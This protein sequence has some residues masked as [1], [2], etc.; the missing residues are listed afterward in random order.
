MASIGQAQETV[1]PLLEK[2]AA[3]Y[4]EGCPGCTIDRRKAEFTG[5]PFAHIINISLLILYGR[6]IISLPIATLHQQ[7]YKRL[8][9]CKESGRHW[10]LCR[11]SRFFIHAW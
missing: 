11:S 9:Y 5:I 3:A 6:F 7:H 2:T 10:A 4:I 1:V 8:E